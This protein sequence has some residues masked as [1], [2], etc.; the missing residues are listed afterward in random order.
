MANNIYYNALS[1][2]LNKYYQ[3]RDF[4]IKV[5]TYLPLP[6]YQ[7]IY[8]GKLPANQR[9]SNASRAYAELELAL[10]YACEMPLSTPIKRD[11]LALIKLFTNNIPPY[12]RCSFNHVAG[13]NKR[14]ESYASESAVLVNAVDEAIAWFIE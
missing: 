12:E 5:R 2:F 9:P 11:F 14:Y 13:A 6:Y 8:V 4:N 7:G 10:G 3:C 1:S